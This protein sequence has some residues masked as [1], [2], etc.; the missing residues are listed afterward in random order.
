MG[1]ERGCVL[2]GGGGTDERALGMEV[3]LVGWVGKMWG[4]KEMEGV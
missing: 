4:W 1:C 3:G 2:G